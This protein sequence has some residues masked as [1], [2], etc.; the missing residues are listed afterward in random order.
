MSEQIHAA[1]QGVQ[2][3]SNQ[4]EDTAA[5]AAQN[6]GERVGETVSAGK[7]AVSEVVETATDK[8]QEI[9][10]EVRRQARDLAGEARSQLKEQ[11]GQQHRKV[12]DGLRSLVS[13]LD[14][15]AGRESSGGMAGEAV[16]QA[17]DRLSSLADWLQD[18]EPEGILEDVRNYARRR[19]GTFLFG[20]AV[21]GV[22]AGRTVRGIAANHSSNGSSAQ[23]AGAPAMGAPGVES[24]ETAAPA[25]TTS[26]VGYQPT[27][28]R[29]VGEFSELQTREMSTTS[30]YS[31]PPL[32]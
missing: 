4:A 15:M 8:G 18:R 20:A 9:A 13:E 5:Q 25:T 31:S 30:G 26:A 23:N 17:R 6:I 10:G 3:L 12:V 24:A 19:P 16:C 1:A 11:A 22:V 2:D 29:D 14:S 27:T 32:R 28:P 21:A 7:E